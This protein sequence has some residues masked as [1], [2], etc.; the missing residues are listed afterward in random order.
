[1]SQSHFTLGFP[2]KSR[3]DTKALADQLTPDDA[4]AV[5]GG[6][7]QSARSTIRALPV[8]SEKT[9]LFLGDFDGEFSRS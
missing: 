3:T 4:G 7:L 5:P 1:M 6:R 2:L 8:L 9:L